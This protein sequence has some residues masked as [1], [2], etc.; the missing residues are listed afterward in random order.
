MSMLTKALYGRWSVI[1]HNDRWHVTDVIGDHDIPF[2][3]DVDAH[4]VANRLWEADKLEASERR[5]VQKLEA[6]HERGKTLCIDFDGVIHHY[7]DGFQDGSIYG[8]PVPNAMKWLDKLHKAGYDLVILSA[9]A[10]D[11]E[12]EDKMR[13]AMREWMLDADVS[14]AFRITTT[15]IPAIAYIDD[16]AIRFT[17]W[18]DIGKLYL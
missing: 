5:E 3:N 15:K 7:P 16:R 9:R 14:F 8:G 2:D 10:N 13:L 18:D 12:Q 11:S 1:L 6:T 4:F 17:N